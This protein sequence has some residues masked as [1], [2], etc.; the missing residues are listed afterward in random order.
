MRADLEYRS[1]PRMALLNAERYSDE[2]AVID[3]DVR[4][5]FRDVGRQMLD[6]ARALV[7][8]DVSPG[9]RVALWAPN[10]AAWIPA[11]LGILATGAWLV[12]LNTRFKAGEAAFVLERSDARAL[13]CHNGFLGI[14]YVGTLR[15]ANPSLR[16]L[17]DVVLLAGD[18]LEDTTSWENFLARGVDVADSV[19]RDRIESIGADDISD[20]I[21]TSG[22]TGLPKGVMLRHGTSLRAY[23]AMNRSYRIGRG[24]RGLIVTPFFHC[25]GYK[26]GWMLTLMTGAT[27]VP[28]AV[29][30]PGAALRTIEELGIT[31]TGGSP[32]MFWSMLDHPTREQR[33]LSSLR[34]T[35]ASAAYVPVELIARTRE[36]M[37]VAHA[38]TGYGLTEAHAIVSI[39]P[40]DDTPEMVASWS[41]RV[42]D[43]VE[44]RIV[45][46]D[47]SDVANGER[48]EL[49]V[50]GFGVMSGYIADPD[51]TA[52][53]IDSE[54]WL[55]TGDIAYTNEDRYLKVCDRIK[56]IYIVGGF[57]VAP[58]EVEGILVDWERISVAAVVGQPDD[59]WGEVGVA[60]VI[61]APGESLEPDDVVAYAREHMAN[62][63]VPRRVIVVDELPMNATGKILKHE[64]RTRLTTPVD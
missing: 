19:V 48:G 20:V 38:L 23:E 64:L 58:A 2:L 40:P 32:T 3:G 41:G 42:I 55:H 7:A 4:M 62:Y 28:V 15:E 51:A 27:A 14:D 35:I 37:G 18:A 24:D 56:D 45:A 47:G 21:F 54:G 12:P 63:K 39:S 26:A 6:V 61:P 1:I 16:A 13:V 33:D 17:R 29:F 22:T 30:D 52:S 53:V 5:T 34:T 49:L 8:S 44:V 10:S 57:N 46:T 31:H 36:D 43:D 60:Y 9:E 59:H 50:R 11:A 25:F